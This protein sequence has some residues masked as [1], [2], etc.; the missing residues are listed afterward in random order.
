VPRIKGGSALGIAIGPMQRA[1]VKAFVAV[2][3]S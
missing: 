1:T 2:I 3:H